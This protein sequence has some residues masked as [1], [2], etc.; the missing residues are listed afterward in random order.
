MTVSSRWTSSPVGIGARGTVSVVS[1]VA[2]RLTADIYQ[3][4]AAGDA[5]RALALHR[6]FLPLAELL[7]SEPNPIPTKAALAMMGGGQTFALRLPLCPM[8]D[9]GQAKLRALLTQMELVS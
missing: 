3:A 4:H 6:R 8:S 1:N 7:F 9:T 2:P 5:G